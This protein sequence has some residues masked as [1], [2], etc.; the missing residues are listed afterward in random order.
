MS[1]PRIALVEDNEDSRVLMRAIL[2]E[3]YDLAEYP[4]GPSALAALRDAPP[5]LILLDVSLPGMDGVEV[6]AHLRDAG[7]R[8]PV[9]AL[10]AHA[11]VGDREALLAR[12]FDDYIS[13]PIVDE[14][15][16]FTAIESLLGSEGA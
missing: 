7:L 15:L 3:R 12:G 13:K 1:R 4:D 2:G 16:L 9:V 10:T 14:S 6:L 5:D 8:L 11:M